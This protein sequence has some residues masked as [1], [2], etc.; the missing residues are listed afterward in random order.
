MSEEI[1]PG[2]ELLLRRKREWHRQLANRP[3]RERVQV[4]IDL[5][6][7]ELPLLERQRPL[8]RLERPW[9]VTP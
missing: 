2:I 9:E 1:R 6:H 4:L 8:R 5:Q 7:Q 3:L